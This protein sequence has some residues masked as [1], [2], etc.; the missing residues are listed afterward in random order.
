MLAFLYSNGSMTC[1]GSLGGANSWA[2]A[3]NA[4][5]QVVGVASTGT[6][7]HAFLYSHGT[8]TDLGMLAG[9][10]SSRAQGI[11]SSGQVV[12]FSYFDGVGDRAFLYSNGTMRSLNDLIDPMSGWSL[13]CANAI[14]DN[15][16]IVGAGVASNGEQ[17][18][19]LLTPVPEPSAIV[20]AGMGIL[21][22]LAYAWR[23]RKTLMQV[24]FSTA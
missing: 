13:F 1:L 4:S 18:A 19:V 3:V 21:S 12:G 23:R 8:M 14:N 10:Q 6:T 22:F 11:N 9:S 15:G 24:P 20:P 5:G 2:T 16:W 17:H 7:G